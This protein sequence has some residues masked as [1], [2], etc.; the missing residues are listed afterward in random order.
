MQCA[1]CGQSLTEGVS[2]CLRCGTPV[3]PGYS[4]KRADV[5]LLPDPVPPSGDNW[6]ETFRAPPTSPYQ[7]FDDHALS[8]PPP[9]SLYTHDTPSY[10][11]DFSGMLPYGLPPYQISQPTKKHGG[12]RLSRW[13]AGVV[14]ALVCLMSLG[15]FAYAHAMGNNKSTSGGGLN[16][17]TAGCG[18]PTVDP[19]AAHN[20]LNP[21]LTTGLKDIK[22]K[23]FAPIDS[24]NT[25]KV[26]QTI[27]FTF[28][29]ISNQRATLTAEWCLGTASNT[30]EYSLPVKNSAGV[31][32]YF[33]LQLQDPTAI[34]HGVLVVRWNNAVAYTDQFTVQAS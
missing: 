19:T 18:V 17:Q 24:T 31:Q 3:P 26:N 6:S 33:D 15:I 5:A 23:N 22:H 20:L 25:F 9:P 14:V 8:A 29:V 12:R 13:V 27:Y 2:V 1:G 10:N 34:G 11:S 28:T 32:G 21:Q 7:H 16:S 30:Y 4:A